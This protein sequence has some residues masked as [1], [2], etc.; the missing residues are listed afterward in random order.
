MSNIVCYKNH[1][2]LLVI[3]YTFKE[4]LPLLCSRGSSTPFLQW[5]GVALHLF[6]RPKINPA[7]WYCVGK[8]YCVVKPFLSPG[9]LITLVFPD[10]QVVAK[11]LYTAS[12][13]VQKIRNFRLVQESRKRQKI[14]N[15]R[16]IKKA[17]YRMVTLPTT[18]SNLF[19]GSISTRVEALLDP[20]VLNGITQSIQAYGLFTG[21]FQRLQLRE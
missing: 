2:V 9:R 20:L 17:T 8:T 10:A 15:G 4:Q 19:S 3:D 11:F 16:L 14:Y 18:L 13:E 6:Q 7:C 1:L 5:Q 21:K 12:S